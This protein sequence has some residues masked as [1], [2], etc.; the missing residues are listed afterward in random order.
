MQSSYYISSISGGQACRSQLK[1]NRPDRCLTLV[2]SAVL[3]PLQSGE[4]FYVVL[5]VCERQLLQK[6]KSKK[7]ICC[8]L[9][10]Y[11]A[12]DQLGYVYT[13]VVLTYFS[14]RSKNSFLGEIRSKQLSTNQNKKYSSVCLW[15]LFLCFRRR[16][17]L[18]PHLLRGRS[19]RFRPWRPGVQPCTL[20][21]T[22]LV[23]IGQKR[24][25]RRHFQIQFTSTKQ[26]G[27]KNKG[28]LSG[29]LRCPRGETLNGALCPAKGTCGVVET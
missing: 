13:Y 7:F 6:L 9:T 20:P 29:N 1:K 22:K 17:C 23:E 25:Q 3:S 16:F 8:Q 15:R 4:M 12:R 21:W 14:L 11:V 5:S 28:R 26:T 27:S 18:D 2:T 24:K 19:L 10:S